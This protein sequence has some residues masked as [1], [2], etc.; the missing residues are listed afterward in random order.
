MTINTLAWNR[1]RYTLY[2]P[3]YD[4]IVKIL[5]HS[6]KQSIES[7]SIRPNDKILIVG[8]GTGFD[9]EFLRTD[10]HIIATD[11]TP[12]MVKRIKKRA[13][14]VNPQAQAIVMNGQALD[15]PD[16]SFDIVI[17]HLILAVIPDPLAC[18]KEV[19]RV[20]KVGGQVAVFDK[21]VPKNRAVSHRRRIA[22]HITNFFFSDITRD[23]YWLIKQT[24][25]K[26]D[27]DIP[28]NFKGNFRRIKLV[29]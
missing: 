22:N 15:F 5:V 13:K 14:L 11:I 1:F 2:T 25:L 3:I 27:F 20:L 26:V 16:A 24:S 21:F 6:R 12:S 7:L 18:I 23:I 28:A 19:D 8:A 4:L 29:K 17:L 9:L 10:C